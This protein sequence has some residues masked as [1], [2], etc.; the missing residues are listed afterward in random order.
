MAR[1]WAEL[2]RVE[3]A[4]R[5]GVSKGAVAQWEH[6]VGT[7]P[8]IK[9]LVMVATVCRVDFDWL[10]SGRGLPRSKHTEEL[11]ASLSEFAHDHD[12]SELLMLWRRCPPAIRSQVLG[13]LRAFGDR[14]RRKLD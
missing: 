1:R 6:P 10:A 13:L 2:S 7:V 8:T 11:A 14:R 4:E 12:E 5:V 9:N 3:L